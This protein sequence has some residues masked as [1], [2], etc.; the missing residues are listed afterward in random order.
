[1]MKEDNVAHG[2]MNKIIPLK[3]LSFPEGEKK[4]KDEKGEW[5]F[6]QQYAC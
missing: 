4:R 2:S 5:K 3:F 1:M 6:G